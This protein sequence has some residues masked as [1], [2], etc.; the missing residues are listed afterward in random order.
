MT[1]SGSDSVTLFLVIILLML[2][3]LLIVVTRRRDP[4]QD[5][6][7]PKPYPVIGN[8]FEMVQIEA[9]D[10]FLKWCK[11]YGKILKYQVFLLGEWHIP[12]GG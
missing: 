3:V 4:L 6:P 2:M 5:I 11:E 7:G 1:G 8:V 10:L 12:V 9:V